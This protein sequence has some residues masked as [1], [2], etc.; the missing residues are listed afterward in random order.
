MAK[1]S[2][3]LDARATKF[4]APIKLRITSGKRTTYIDTG[5]RTDESNWDYT[6]RR[7][8]IGKEEN[9]W[10]NKSITRVN[11]YVLDPGFHFDGS[12]KALYKM[13][14]DLSIML[15]GYRP[16]PPRSRRFLPRFEAF[17][18]SRATTGTR[19]V[20]ERSLIA[21]SKFDPYLDKRSFADIDLDY[22]RRFEA[23]C[24]QTMKVN[25]ISIIMR[26]IRAVFND[27]IADNI[28]ESYPFRK[29]K[30][31]QEE[32]KKRSLNV[33]QVRRLMNERLEPFMVEYRDM[34]L[35]MMYLGGINMVD[36]FEAK[37]E[38][39]VNGRLVYKRAKTGTDYS[40]KIEP[41]AME[42]IRRYRGEKYLLSPLDRYASVLDYRQHMNR[43]L[44]AIG[45]PTGK[46]G[47]ILGKGLFPEL[48]SYWARHTVATLA[49]DLGY[50]IDLI[51]QMLGHK[52]RGR[53]I[54]MIYIRLDPTRVDGMIRDIID[55]IHGRK[56]TPKPT[57]EKKKS[58]DLDALMK[59]LQA[60]E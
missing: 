57:A 49:Y 18:D 25:T 10:L 14:E 6:R 15:V 59:F 16:L 26:N 2:Y 44:K 51:A 24:K 41:E 45:R 50:S 43:A 58:I 60:Q 36:L 54:T 13:K 23:W 12:E 56:N 1:F 20:Y 30:I 21:L 11:N 28:T 27:A 35:L 19:S 53:E 34:F 42:I 55:Y 40:V 39:I 33:E 31:Q 17:R 22:L 29:F 48:S 52:V 3:Y 4:N 47:K 7:L 37:P 46:K 32:T 5:I 9:D 38:Q 8:Y